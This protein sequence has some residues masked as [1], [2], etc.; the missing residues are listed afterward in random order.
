VSFDR[1]FLANSDL[2]IYAK[3]QLMPLES[4]K[5]NTVIFDRD[6]VL[7]GF[8]HQAMAAFFSPLL[9]LSLSEIDNLL[10]NWGKITG[11]P[12]TAAKERLFWQKFCVFLK[13]KLSLTNTIYEQLKT[14][15]YLDYMYS[16]PDS[17]LA[18]IAAKN[19]KLK[20]GVL[21]NS[22]MTYLETS[23]TI[24]EFSKCIDIAYASLLDGVVKPNP[25]AYLNLIKALETKAENCLFFDDKIAHFEA[26]LNLDLEA[27]LVD[28]NIENH[29]IEARI[30]K[31]LSALE[32]IL[33]QNSSGHDFETI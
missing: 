14:F 22:P 6:G 8:D 33:K 31:D 4:K 24:F 7:I 3:I 18:L 12:T 23:L 15:N 26:A 25:I 21:S 10:Q 20:T 16:F 2:L 29:K 9:P 5:I 28:R 11:F 1:L 19:H 13:Q 32:I 30:V 17:K 27:Y